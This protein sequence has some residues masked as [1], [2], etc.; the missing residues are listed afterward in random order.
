MK[1]SISRRAFLKESGAVGTLVALNS[2]LPAYARAGWIGVVAP[3]T[4]LSGN[5]IDLTIAESPFRVNDR[6]ATAM[7]ING[8]VPGPLLRLREGQ[9]ITLNVTNRLSE[10]SS[11]HLH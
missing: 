4:Q 8:T 9:D 1:D 11:I 7:T 2:M 10:D 3:T 6:T 5:V